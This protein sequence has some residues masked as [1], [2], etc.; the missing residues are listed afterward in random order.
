MTRY[1]RGYSRSRLPLVLLRRNSS[2]GT[3]CFVHPLVTLPSQIRM[4]PVETEVR[5]CVCC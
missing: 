5:E 3:S 1:S 4:A 2:R